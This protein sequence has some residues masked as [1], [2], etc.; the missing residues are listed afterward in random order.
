M[1]TLTTL[2]ILYVTLSIFT[3]IVWTLLAVLLYR[4]IKITWPVVEILSYYKQFKWY[5]SSYSQIPQAVKDKV[6]EMVSNLK[7]S[8]QKKED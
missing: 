6:F 7:K 2:D 1:Q 5:V 4:V 3:A 8:K